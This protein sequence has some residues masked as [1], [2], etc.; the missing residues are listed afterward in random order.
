MASDPSAYWFVA[1]QGRT[2]GPYLAGMVEDRLRQGK[3]SSDS[4]VWNAGMA[5]W[6][7][8]ADYFPGPP[9]QGPRAAAGSPEA[10]GRLIA[11]WLSLGVAVATTASYLAG[12]PN[13]HEQ[14]AG[15]FL[16]ARLGTIA[17]MLFGGAASML[18]WWAR[19]SFPC[20]RQTPSGSIRAATT[21]AAASLAIIA[22]VAVAETPLLYRIHV[23]RDA[24]R[25]YVVLSGARHATISIVGP[26]GPALAA[27]V[28]AAL[29]SGTLIKTVTIRS[30]GGLVDEALATAREIQSRGNIAVVARNACDSACIIVFMS[31]SRRIAPWN[32]NFGFHALS[33]IANLSGPFSLAGVQRISAGA[34][35]YMI[36]RGV[37]RAFLAAAGAAGPERVVR[38]SAIR[39]AEVGAVTQLA[40]GGEPITIE[41]AKW[42][43]FVAQVQRT[44][45][46][47]P[48]VALLETVDRYV[49]QAT[50]EY[51]PEFWA[52][53]EAGNEGGV[54]TYARELIAA[55]TS[56]SL[57]A[58]DDTALAAF[59][60]VVGAELDYI[61][62]T[63][64]WDACAS[65]LAG[66]GLGALKI[67]GP[68]A[69]AEMN[70][71]AALIKSAARERWKAQSLPPWAIV[72][73]RELARSVARSMLTR[74]E[75]ISM[76]RSSPR[77][78]CDWS[79]NLL[80]AIARRPPEEA[81]GLYR[82]L[83]ARK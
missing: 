67:P 77:V 59:V 51:G 8:L 29:G 64:S 2:H 22:I 12:M 42:L 19:S 78:A 80:G 50:L 26:I 15:R 4:L 30:H 41:R 55:V 82:E 83:L 5:G 18:L 13:L 45:P 34:N 27:E 14:E 58:A 28:A 38:V 60:R 69:D 6:R 47:P 16:M 79:A 81:A 17:L 7:S 74:G 23:A 35:A 72:E 25:H 49:P 9:V 44:E 62:S 39:M 36:E 20:I 63:G 40:S 46:S 10:T 54:A 53:A 65:F 33:P 56:Q 68:L 52:M 37:P 3:F 61:R 75:S 73:L 66:K 43:W 11:R 31:G 76:L 70:A 71:T 48:L 1:E 24:F 57:P 21:I 32:L